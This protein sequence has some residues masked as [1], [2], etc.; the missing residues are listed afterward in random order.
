MPLDTGPYEPR[1]KFA[2]SSELRRPDPTRRKTGDFVFVPCVLCV[3]L[4]GLFLLVTRSYKHHTIFC[5]NGL[6][7]S[8]SWYGPGAPAWGRQGVVAWQASGQQYA[9]YRRGKFEIARAQSCRSGRQRS[10]ESPA[11]SG[12]CRV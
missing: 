8:A 5:G 3:C 7:T 11:I 1:A 4:L 6:G 9:T 12:C 2:L 10:A